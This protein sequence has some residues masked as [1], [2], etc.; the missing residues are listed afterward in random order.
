MNAESWDALGLALAIVALMMCFG[1]FLWNDYS[2]SRVRVERIRLPEASK[3]LRDLV[4]SHT[5][6]HVDKG[7]VEVGCEVR[8]NDRHYSHVYTME[9]SSDGRQLIYM[10][11]RYHPYGSV[12]GSVFGP[13]EW[14]YEIKFFS[15]AKRRFYPED[16][17]MAMAI[18]SGRKDKQLTVTCF[19]SG[20]LVHW[21]FR[22]SKKTTISEVTADSFEDAIG[23]LHSAH[24]P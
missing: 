2:V 18:V 20:Y 3:R 13:R 10:D 17:G 9:S 7:F 14:D 15:G 4:A 8:W 24:L 5:Y 11:L 19:G 23:A 1:V 12:G 22:R 16:L 6:F 21:L